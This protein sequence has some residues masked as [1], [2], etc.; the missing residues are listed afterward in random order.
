MNEKTLHAFER[1]MNALN[2]NMNFIKENTSEKE[3]VKAKFDSIRILIDYC[4]E[5][6]LGNA[7]VD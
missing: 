5:L 2:D 1:N 4:E 3:V 6:A 7:K